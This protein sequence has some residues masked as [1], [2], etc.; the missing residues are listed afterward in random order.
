MALD[1]DLDCPE[2]L[3]VA[4]ILLPATGWVFGRK[5]APRSHR[6]YR[7]DRSLDAASKKYT[8]INEEKTTLVELRGTGGQTVYPPSLHE[9]TGG[10]IA[11][12]QFGQ[13][14][15]VSLAELQRSVAEVT[16]CCLLA[17][18]WPGKGTRQ[19]TYMAL[20][21][22]LLRAGW[23]QDRVERF[24]GALA[25]ATHDDEQQKRVRIVAQTCAKQQDDKKTTGWPNQNRLV[26]RKSD[27]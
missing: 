27:C 26:C 14:G 4:P 5:S 3:L 25:A 24:V 9:D 13:P 23:A 20:T 22:G 16:A 12:D 15:E 18:H 2:S 21:G 10:L 1:A 8:D 11:W 19:D 17:R 6:I 7:A